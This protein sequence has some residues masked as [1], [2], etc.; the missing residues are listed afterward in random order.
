MSRTPR[1]GRVQAETAG[2]YRGKERRWRPSSRSSL[3][4]WRLAG[5][6]T[7][8]TAGA[9]FAADSPSTGTPAPQPRRPRRHPGRSA[10]QSG[11]AAVKVVVDTV[12]GTRADLRGGAQVARPSASTPRA[13]Q[14]PAGRHR[15]PG[16]RGRRQGRPAGRQ[17]Q[18]HPGTGGHHQEQGA[19]PCQQ[20]GEP[21]VRSAAAADAC[22]SARSRCRDARRSPPGGHLRVRSPS[23]R[24]G[25]KL[26]VGNLLPRPAGARLRRHERSPPWPISP[27]TS[28]RTRP[29]SRS[30]STTSPRTSSVPSPTSGTSGR[31]RPGP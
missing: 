4:R 9:A 5:A 20:G 24:T 3:R 14:D 23:R 19:G 17:R 18:D 26:L 2:T 13:G 16:E 10:E 1:L 7:A 12:G 31:R 11:E 21:P 22:R 30:G 28:T 8:G 6:I 15:R 25:G 29:R 27:S